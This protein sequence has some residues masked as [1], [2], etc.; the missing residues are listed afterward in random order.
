MYTSKGGSVFHRS[1]S[2]EALLEGQRK[3]AR[4]GQQIHEPRPVPLRQAQAEGRGAC[5]PCFPNFVPANAKPCWIRGESTWL[6]GLL[7]E[8]HKD[9]ARKVWRGVVTYSVGSEQITEVREQKELR[10]RR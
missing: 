4:F 10:P 6:P 5:I 3:A 2:C 1:A 7:L 9:P 8:W